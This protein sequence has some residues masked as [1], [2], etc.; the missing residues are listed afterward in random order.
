MK[1][2]IM[3][4]M[5]AL[6]ISPITSISAST[7]SESTDEPNAT[8]SVCPFNVSE[9]SSYIPST[10]VLSTLISQSGTFEN[11]TSEKQS[12]TLSFSRTVKA[13]LSGGAQAELNLIGNK[14]GYHAEI[15]VGKS[16]TVSETTKFTIPAYHTSHYK[17]GSRL[18]KTSGK[19]DKWDARCNH[20]VKNVSAEYTYEKY[21]YI[22]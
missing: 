14:V 6:L 1:K 17:V 13:S 11:K 3:C 19:I 16:T 20:T 21:D 9:V 22:D 7:S 15:S 5:T 4:L 2:L 8:R 12:K 10:K 18:I